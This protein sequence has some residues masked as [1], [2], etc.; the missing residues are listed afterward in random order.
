M[1]NSEIL[2]SEKRVTQEFKAADG[3]LSSIIT[4][5]ITR[6][7]GAEETLSSSI[8]QNAR[9]ITLK[10]SKGDVSSQLSMENDQ[11][12]ISSNRISISSTYFTLTNDGKI[13]CTGADISGTLKTGGNYGYVTLENGRLIG[14][15]NSNESGYITFNHTYN[16]NPAPRIAGKSGIILST[17]YL[18][19]GPYVSPG[20]DLTVYQ[21]ESGSQSFVTNIS[22]NGDGTIS[23]T[24]KTITFT[25]GL[26]TTSL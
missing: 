21:G 19:V 16:S 9:N 11:I 20:S 4:E 1:L 3:E 5:E 8:T 23:W 13:S 24:T 12:S 17:P 18:A 2:D 7:K 15:F 10:V 22:D 6:A 25:K 26:M 14:G